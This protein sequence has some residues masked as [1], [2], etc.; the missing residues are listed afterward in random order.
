MLDAEL[1]VETAD[2]NTSSAPPE[3]LSL[4]FSLKRYKVGKVALQISLL[5]FTHDPMQDVFLN[6]SGMCERA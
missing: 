3:S 2:S 6:I 1:E 4:A 5:P